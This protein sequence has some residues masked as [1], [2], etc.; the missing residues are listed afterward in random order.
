[1]KPTRR[2]A[3]MK[4]VHTQH[5]DAMAMAVGSICSTSLLLGRLLALLLR[6]G[7]LLEED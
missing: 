6:K 2:V 3:R 4:D 1:M 5:L 7:R